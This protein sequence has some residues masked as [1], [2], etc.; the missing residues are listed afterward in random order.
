MTFIYHNFNQPNTGTNP[1]DPV[2]ASVPN[3]L[4]PFLLANCDLD[5][6]VLLDLRSG[7]QRC[8]NEVLR[9]VAAGLLCADFDALADGVLRGA[10]VKNGDALGAQGV[11]M[12]H[13]WFPVFSM[14]F[15]LF[16]M[17]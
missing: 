4:V 11:L 2:F 17:D 13:I 6:S 16:S 5:L 14:V 8:H 1:V 10:D 12:E 7:L 15:L 9:H 3:Q